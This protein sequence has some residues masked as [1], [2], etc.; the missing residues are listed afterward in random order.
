MSAVRI[1]G[2]V[3]PAEVAAVLALLARDAREQETSAY[4]RWRAQRLQA[5]RRTT[6]TRGR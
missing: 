2:A 5:L 6:A 3:D 4:D 1:K